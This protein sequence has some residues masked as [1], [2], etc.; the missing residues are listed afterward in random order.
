MKIKCNVV[1]DLLPL[2]VD[3]VVSEE[4]R[5]LVD[6]HM[7]ACGECRDYCRALRESEKPIPREEFSGELEPLKKIKRRNILNKIALVVVAVAFVAGAGLFIST[8]G[9]TDS[10][11]VQDHA[12][13]TVPEGYE[14]Q[15]SYDGDNRQVYV[16][17]TEETK[18]SL[19]IT[20][21]DR[22]SVDWMET[23]EGRVSVGKGWE[24]WIYENDYDHTRYNTLTALMY[25]DQDTYQIDYSCR[26]LDREDYCDSCS[27]EQQDA[28]VAF[29]R[30]FEHKEPPKEGNVFTR[31]VRNL[32]TA[33][34][35]ILGL[36]VLIFVGFPLAIAIVSLTGGSGDGK[37]RGPVSSEDLRKEMNRER[38]AKGDDQLPAI[39]NVA[40]VSSNSLARRDK[41]WS[42]VPDFFIKMFKRK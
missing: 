42:S 37:D 17:R 35:I 19:T 6:E 21:E 41:S 15:G 29:M 18:E 7:K 22:H 3:D 40:G 24:G 28:M 25:Y 8:Q 16:R 27:R 4:S 9:L 12:E 31:L 2:Y 10:W 14:L 36:T 1:R 23:E 26:I 33:G 5:E 38:E 30:T 34:M 13:F 20:Y 32:G 11:R 39:N